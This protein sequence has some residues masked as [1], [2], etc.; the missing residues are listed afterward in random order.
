M[1]RAIISACAALAL[2]GGLSTPAHAATQERA[3][4]TDCQYATMVNYLDRLDSG[5]PNNE[6]DDKIDYDAK[7]SSWDGDTKVTRTFSTVDTI[8]VWIKKLTGPNSSNYETVAHFGKFGSIDQTEWFE[9]SPYN[10]LQISVNRKPYMKVTVER[11]DGAQCSM[12]TAWNN[13]W[14]P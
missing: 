12:F 13:N 7:P 1:K 11:A 14:T 10:D 5:T 4:Y 6:D 3:K 8:D 9:F 2:V